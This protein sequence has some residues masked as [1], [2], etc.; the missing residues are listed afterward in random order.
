MRVLV[1]C[2]F[3]AGTLAP[4]NVLKKEEKKEEKKKKMIPEIPPEKEKRKT[5]EHQSK[6]KVALNSIQNIRDDKGFL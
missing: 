1:A 3:T 5:K 6:P 2:S 4:R